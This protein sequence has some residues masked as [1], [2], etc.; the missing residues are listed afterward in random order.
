MNAARINVLRKQ[1]STGFTKDGVLTIDDTG[2]IKPYAKK[3]GG[4]SYQY[5]PSVKHEAYYNVTVVNCYANATK[6]IPLNLRIYKPEAEFTPLGKDEPVKL[7]LP[8]YGKTNENQR[9]IEIA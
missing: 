7:I 4:V 5:C 6:H 9:N 2:S 8:L 3:A 1:R